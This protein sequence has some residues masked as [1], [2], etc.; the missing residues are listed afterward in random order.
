MQLWVEGLWAPQHDSWKHEPITFIL[1]LQTAK[2]RAEAR[3]EALGSAGI[4]VDEWLAENVHNDEDEVDDSATDGRISPAV[5]AQSDLSD[6]VCI[7]VLF[8][9][10]I[11]CR[12]ALCI[13]M[14][15]NVF[16]CVY[17]KNWYNYELQV[18]PHPFLSCHDVDDL[19]LDLYC[20]ASDGVLNNFMPNWAYSGCEM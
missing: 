12:F 18:H 13:F 2:A 4:N 1:F 9:M 3:L 15:V 7:N 6:K 17:D 20:V 16:L 19:I 11:I 5:S 14:Y 10:D 8:L